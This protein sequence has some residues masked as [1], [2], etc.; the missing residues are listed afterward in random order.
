MINLATAELVGTIADVIDNE[1]WA[2]AGG[3]RSIEHWVSWQ[4]GV[5][6]ERAKSLVVSA[7]RLAELPLTAAVFESGQLSEESMAAIARRVPA[8]RD[9]EVAPL[10]AQLLHSQL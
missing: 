6:P 1:T 4:C 8:D 5:S 3:V 10:A 7:R 9:H 2:I